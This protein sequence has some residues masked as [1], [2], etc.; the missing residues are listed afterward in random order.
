MNASAV[1]HAHYPDNVPHQIDPSRY[2]S[3]VE[4]FTTAVEEHGNRPAFGNFGCYLSYAETFR[5]A[6]SFA[7]YLCRECNIKPG[8]RVAIML[9]NVLAYP[10]A[11][12][13]I[14]MTGASVVNINPQYTSRELSHQLENS[15]AVAIIVL[16][17]LLPNLDVVYRDTAL[18]HVVSAEIGDLLKPLKG[19]LIN[20]LIRL[21]TPRID[22][23]NIG[24]STNFRRCLKLGSREQTPQVDIHPDD[25]AFLQYTG[26]T[27]GLSKG[28][29][30]S[31]GNIVANVL[32]ISS[33]FGDKAEPGNEIVVTALPLY[34]IY[35]LT[36]NCFCF[37]HHGSLV[38]L[39][40][41]PRNV[42]RFIKEIKD[43]KFSA[44]SGVN[45][46]YNLLLSD[47]SFD[48]ID[49]SRLKYA[50]S[51]GMAAQSIVA[52]NWQ[53]KTQIF[54]GESYGLTEASPA[55]CSTP[56]GIDYFTGTVGVPLPS[57]ECS[58]RNERGDALGID[59][60][61]ELWVRGPQVMKGYW[62]N[63]AATRDTITADGWLKTGDIARMNSEGMISIVDRAKDM[64]IV[65]GF[66]VYPNE[67]EDVAA[68]HPDLTEVAVIGLP[69]DVAGEAVTLVAVSTNPAL[70]E[71]EL[72]EF[73]R[74]ELTGYKRP[75]RVIFVNELPKSNVGKILRRKVREMI[76]QDHAS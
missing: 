1:W 42:K 61:G 73:C 20:R 4:L 63:E 71:K 59:E 36:F 3:I 17:H 15:G 62:Q 29:M 41:D 22:L 12:L 47:P 51:G 35:A 11:M 18:K 28:A 75:S 60:P 14:L 70:D 33:F 54:L 32:Q 21:K 24:N 72:I 19:F 57:T 25:I 38:Y 34:H 67:V 39:I 52:Q 30:L 2:R 50:S 9:P 49:F 65:S 27:T 43:L 76:R 26:G 31:H 48:D 6:T 45:T 37:L 23:E 58:I 16:Q 40:T 10:V 64:I 74:R 44:I 5:L 55:V 68:Q 13:G 66:N 46:L 56:P 8:D 7:A 69:D 53:A